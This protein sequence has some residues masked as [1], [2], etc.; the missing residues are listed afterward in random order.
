MIDIKNQGSIKLI[1]FGTSARYDHDI[2]QMHA[3]LGTAYY[4]AP[5]VFT[6]R[7]DRG[8]NEK[9]DMW[10]IGVLLYIML[11]GHPPF[12]GATVEIILERVRRGVYYFVG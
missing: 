11:C 12:N 9:C 8:Y 10:S 1:D 6:S 3:S 7:S 4:V 5:E 2:N